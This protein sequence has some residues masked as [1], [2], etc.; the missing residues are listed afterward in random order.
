MDKSKLTEKEWLQAIRAMAPDDARWFAVDGFGQ[1]R[2]WPDNDEHRK[3]CC[4]FPND[5]DDV[6]EWD[7]ET[8]PCGICNFGVD[9]IFL[10]D[11]GDAFPFAAEDSCL[12]L[13]LDDDACLEG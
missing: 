7:G 1:G 6:V 2:Y 13:Y 12:D 9:Q 8:E 10:V 4:V 3:P 5:E 11:V